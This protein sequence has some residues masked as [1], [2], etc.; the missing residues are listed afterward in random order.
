MDDETGTRRW[1]RIS[2]ADDD[3]VQLLRAAILAVRAAPG[4]AEQRRRLHARATAAP[5]QA[6]LLI[7]DEA[8]AA[9]RDEVAAA[10]YEELADLHED[11]DQPLETIAAMEQ[12]VA[13]A[14]G[15]VDHRDRLARLYH[16]AGA[17]AKAAEAFEQVAELARDDRARA[18][19]RA[20]GR[21]Y[22]DNGRLER[23]VA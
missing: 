4:D 17:W 20:A 19:L 8:R 9:D 11:L 3:P 14:P 2:Q 23:A 15:E 6:A 12:L 1:R 5:E 7:A 21:L 22:R 10:F 18:A 16:R 13:L